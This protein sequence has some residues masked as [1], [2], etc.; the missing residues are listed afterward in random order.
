MLTTVWHLQH[1]CLVQGRRVS[2]GVYETLDDAAHGY[3]SLVR[4]YDGPEAETNYR[5]GPLEGVRFG[6]NRGAS[7]C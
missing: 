7:S 2:A 1:S 6:W 3:D 5:L 4:M